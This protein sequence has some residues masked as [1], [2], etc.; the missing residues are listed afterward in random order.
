VSE[1]F[2]FRVNSFP[3]AKILRSRSWN[4]FSL[5]KK[6]EHFGI[7]VKMNGLECVPGR[8]GTNLGLVE[9]L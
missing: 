2:V 6:L 3:Q 5:K 1:I 9:K 7:T 8:S 4:N